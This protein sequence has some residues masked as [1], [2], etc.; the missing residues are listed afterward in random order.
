MR[1]FLK[2]ALSLCLNASLF[3]ETRV[4]G[5]ITDPTGAAVPGAKV[6]LNCGSKN[7][8]ASAD[9]QGKYSFVLASAVPCTLT[10][11]QT[12]FKTKTLADLRIA[13]QPV[14]QLNVALEV[15]SISEAI[16]VQSG[17]VGA[18]YGTGRGAAAYHSSGGASASTMY[19]RLHRVPPN[20]E[21]YRKLP[22]NGFFAVKQQP[23]STFSTDADTASFSNTRRFLREGTLPPPDAVRVEEFLNSFSYRF[24]AP[25]GDE[26]LAVHTE[27]GPCPW[28]PA[29]KLLM[30]GLK[31]KALASEALPPANLV[32]LL[33]VSGSMN[34]PLKL[35]L[36][37]QSFSL[38]VEQLRPQDTVSIVVYAGASGVVLEPTKGNEKPQ[39]LDVLGKLHAGGSTNGAAGIQLAYQLAGK[40]FI[41]GG[42]NRV[43]LATDG[44][45]NVG[46]S[47]D[48]DLVRLI[49]EKRKSGIFLTVLGY[50][51]GNYKDGRLEQIANAGNGNFAYIDS[52]LE[53]RKFLVKEF[54]QNL[55][56]VAKDVKLQVEFNPRHIKEYRLIGYENRLLQ[57]QD[58]RDDQKDAGE[59]GSGHSVVALYELVPH[60]TANQ[61]GEV[62][63]LRYLKEAKGEK[64]HEEELLFVRVRYKKPNEETSK[65]M[66]A[67]VA[68][69]TLEAKLDPTSP[70]FRFAAGLA[71]FAQ[72]LSKS[73]WAAQSSFDSARALIASSLSQA[74]DEQRSLLPLMIDRAVELQKTAPKSPTQ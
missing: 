37:K 10:V 38:L 74:P 3:A 68:V 25:R 24:P 54:G 56:T 34:D 18:G 64:S 11:A 45:F 5:T 61:S 39:I 46:V 33:D 36:L 67:P 14:L 50:G 22:E 60:D 72:L 28:Q 30:I 32:F 44:D 66:S 62:D 16:E 21:N 35:P 31:T 7:F 58:F 15:G 53:A 69:S 12:G 55:V 70:D 52:I 49:E 9:A 73:K 2:V 65:E 47:S 59:L 40:S 20:T 4:D 27:A 43:I 41:K 29:H 6:T 48:G 57:A 1:S 19:F 26:P 63:A 23:L 71:E 8:T 13:D 51:M 17:A 42:N